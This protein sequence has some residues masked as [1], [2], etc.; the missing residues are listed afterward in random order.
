M[1]VAG[2]GFRKGTSGA[3]IIAAID[4]A[5]AA[6]GVERGQVGL[7]AT[8]QEKVGDTGIIEAAQ[9]LGLPAVGVD[10]MELQ[11]QKTITRSERSLATT[12]VPSLSEAAALAAA[13]IN[14]R[15]LGPRR[16][17]GSVTC[18]LAEVIA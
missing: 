18:A 1:I 7:I 9:L 6:H 4:A 16:S 17:L 15:L 8:S 11:V 13:G 2:I 10:D 5:L 14:A 12:G 3:E